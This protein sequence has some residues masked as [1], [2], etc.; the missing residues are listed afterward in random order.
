MFGQYYIIWMCCNVINFL[1]DIS[2]VP[3][4]ENVPAD[5]AA[6]KSPHTSHT[7]FLGLVSRDGMV[8]LSSM[9]FSDT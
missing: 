7:M 6:Y 1:L 9:H 3:C 4:L 2:V 5:A 8:G